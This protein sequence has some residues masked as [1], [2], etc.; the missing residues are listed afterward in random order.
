MSVS[1]NSLAVS[2]NQIVA[3]LFIIRYMQ[4]LR[5]DYSF[6]NGKAR[7]RREDEIE[8]GADSSWKRIRF[9]RQRIPF[10]FA[11]YSGDK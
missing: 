4:F 5:M 3:A 2:I 11:E 10:Y 8:D 9:N 1:E 6:F 7:T